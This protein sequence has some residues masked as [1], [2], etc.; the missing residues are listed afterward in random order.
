MFIFGHTGIT[1]AA[2]VLFKGTF[3]RSHAPA[4]ST[5]VIQLSVFAVGR[6]VCSL[7]FG[8]NV[9]SGAEVDLVGR[10]AEEC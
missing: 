4:S 2:A 5:K 1:L 9:I 3:V 7:E 6:L 8:R 10:L